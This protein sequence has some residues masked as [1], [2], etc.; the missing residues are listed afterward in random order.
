MTIL[1]SET[2]WSFGF[3]LDPPNRGMARHWGPVR[4]GSLLIWLPLFWVVLSRLHSFLKCNNSHLLVLP[5]Q[6]PGLCLSVTPFLCFFHTRAGNCSQLLLL[7]ADFFSS[8][9]LFT[10]VRTGSVFLKCLLIRERER[11]KVGEGQRERERERE[12][13]PSRLHAVSA[14]PQAGAQSHDP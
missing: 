6:L 4:Q 11:K 8:N 3:L 5:L 7:L 1:N 10:G 12:R 13:L 14:E 2:S 9:L